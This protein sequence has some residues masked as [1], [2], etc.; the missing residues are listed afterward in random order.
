MS[1]EL[2]GQQLALDFHEDEQE[3]G[4]T[5]DAANVSMV[6][7]FGGEEFLIIFRESDSEKLVSAAERIR[8]IVSKHDF[9]V[10]RKRITLSAGVTP[11][12]PEDT[13]T[14]LVERADRAMYASKMK[15]RD[16]T[17]YLPYDI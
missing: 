17:T 8:L 3:R 10:H 16:C 6:H 13:I 4:I 1:E 14:S 15:G 5:I 7:H 9:G 12:G 2:A 11:A